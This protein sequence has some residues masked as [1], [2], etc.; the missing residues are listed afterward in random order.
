FP[1]Y[2]KFVQKQKLHMF[3]DGYEAPSPFASKNERLMDL[4]IRL[5]RFPGAV[6]EDELKEF[7]TQIKAIERTVKKMG[8]LPETEKEILNFSRM[9]YKLIIDVEDEEPPKPEEE[10]SEGGP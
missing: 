2:Q 9:L 7:S 4:L 6:E 5:L 3:N 8:G 1:G 10:D